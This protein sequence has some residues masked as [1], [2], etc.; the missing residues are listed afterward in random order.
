MKITIISLAL[1]FPWFG[2]TAFCLHEEIGELGVKQTQLQELTTRQKDFMTTLD[3]QIGDVE[4]VDMAEAISRLT[5]T[6]TSLEASYR[7]LSATRDMSL[8]NFL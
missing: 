6:Q 5:F 3:I 8:A 7:M 1:L 2:I 4:D